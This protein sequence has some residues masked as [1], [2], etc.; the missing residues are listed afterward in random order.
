[1]AGF[2]A[3]SPR[4][5]S[6]I[7]L[8]WFVPPFEQDPF[9]PF[10]KRSWVGCGSLS[11]SLMVLV[12]PRWLVYLAL[13]LLFWFP[14]RWFLNWPPGCFGGGVGFIFGDDG[15]I[16]RF[17]N[18]FLGFTIFRVCFRTGCSGVPPHTRVR[19]LPPPSLAV[20]RLV[21]PSPVGKW[22]QTPRF[23]K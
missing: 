3:W 6:P 5:V 19:M 23:L 4:I 22:F 12:G 8:I 11:P 18:Q 13:V 1:M 10:G 17:G 16:Y 21:R 20:L 15:W 9:I 14:S 2:Q 7:N